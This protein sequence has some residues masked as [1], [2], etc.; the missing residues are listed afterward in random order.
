MSVGKRSGVV[1]FPSSGQTT[2]PKNLS[3]VHMRPVNDTKPTTHHDRVE[4]RSI[5]RN[6]KPEVALKS[7]RGFDTI[8]ERSHARSAD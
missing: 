6:S 5:F 7:T 4:K 1:M 2:H 3:M 8:V